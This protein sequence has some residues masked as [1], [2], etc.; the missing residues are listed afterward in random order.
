MDET[1]KYVCVFVST[2]YTSY[3][4]NRQ[5]SPGENKL[6]REDYAFDPI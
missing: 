2:R 5:P 1:P 6:R 4:I 3:L